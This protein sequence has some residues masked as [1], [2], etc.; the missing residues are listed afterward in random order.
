VGEVTIARD[1]VLRLQFLAALT[2]LK[3]LVIPESLATLGLYRLG[4]PDLAEFAPLQLADWCSISWTPLTSLAGLENLRT[5]ASR[6]S[7]HSNENLA[8][9][10]ALQ[11]VVSVGS[12][13]VKFADNPLLDTCAVEEMVAGWEVSGAVSISGN[14]PCAD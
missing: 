11:G 2:D 13:G 5:V 3:G 8:D 7:I 1:G 10:S 14:G 9:I 4:I 6:L 12:Q